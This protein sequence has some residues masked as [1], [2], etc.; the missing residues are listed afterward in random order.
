M[1]ESIRASV[2]TEYESQLKTERA[3]WEAAIEELKK[4]NSEK[5]NGSSSAK[6][7]SSSSS[8]DTAGQQINFNEALKRTMESK[9]KEMAQLRE[10]GRSS[11]IFIQ[12]FYLFIIFFLNCF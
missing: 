8:K 1:V 12:F 2:A 5:S 4:K 10:Q 11:P 3:K 7:S 9:E 6:K